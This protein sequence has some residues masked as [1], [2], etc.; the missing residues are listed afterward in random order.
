M[1]S[2]V[3]IT[4]DPVN[5]GPVTITPD[6]PMEHPYQSWLDRE[7][8]LTSYGAA[9]EQGIQSIARGGRDLAT[10]MVNAISHPIEAIKGIASLPSQ[11]AQVP[12]AVKDINQSA[13]PLGTFAKVGQETAG[14]GAAQTLAALATEGVIK[15]AGAVKDA[16]PNA[17]RAGTTL[18]TIKNIAGNVPIDTS[19]VG[20]SALELYEQSQRGATLPTAVG[21]L[22]RRLTTPDS[23]PMTYEEAKDFQSNISSLS[24]NEKMSLKPNQVRLVGQLNSSLKD[25]LEDAADT[26]IRL[27]RGQTLQTRCRNT[28]MPCG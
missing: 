7:I 21:K 17:Q 8:P 9:T 4:P 15:G 27:A 6:T 20:D 25:A 18:Q 5:A 2:S 23:T 10:G 22:V 26:V 14:Q 13:D 24:A 1:G 19:Q 28:A 3:T 16:L 12:A 11:A